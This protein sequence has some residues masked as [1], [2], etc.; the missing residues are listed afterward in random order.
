[1]NEIVIV[2]TEGGKKS[3]NLWNMFVNFKEN[4]GI[5]VVLFVVII[6][7]MIIP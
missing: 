7:C 4:G 2:D 6:I 1:M 5:L 3:R